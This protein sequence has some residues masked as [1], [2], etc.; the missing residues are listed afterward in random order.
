MARSNDRDRGSQRIPRD[1]ARRAG[2][3]KVRI[4]CKDHVGWVDHKDLNLLRRFMSDRA[5]I[6][7]RRVT[8][9]V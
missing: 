2:K 7:A 9:E 8:D 3:K 1:L 6:R 5:K 4:F